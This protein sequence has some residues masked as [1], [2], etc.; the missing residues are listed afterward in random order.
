MIISGFLFP[1]LHFIQQTSP[2]PCSESE[3]SKKHNSTPVQSYLSLFNVLWILVLLIH[4]LL[5][6]APRICFLF[7]CIFNIYSTFSEFKRKSL[8]A[9]TSVLH[10]PFTQLPLH[11]S[12]AKLLKSH[13]LF[14][15]PY[16]PFSIQCIGIWL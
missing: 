3:I 12:I 2:S 5:V 15:L 13:S 10:A 11:L 6:F 4:F 9:A 1:T 14:L 8:V 16:C 7:K